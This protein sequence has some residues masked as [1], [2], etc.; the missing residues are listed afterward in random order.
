MSDRA[1]GKLL[2]KSRSL[3]R[4]RGGSVD[5][6]AE[7]DTDG[8]SIGSISAAGSLP[9]GRSRKSS[10]RRSHTSD[11]LGDGQVDDDEVDGPMSPV[12]VEVSA[13]KEALDEDPSLTPCAS[14]DTEL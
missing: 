11:V 14:E 2:R 1:L 4:G 9:R 7:G 10:I 13:D 12:V 3:R 6:D 5:A 8:S